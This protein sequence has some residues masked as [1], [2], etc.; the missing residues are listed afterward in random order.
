MVKDDDEEVL[1]PEEVKGEEYADQKLKKVPSITSVESLD[2]DLPLNSYT[3]DLEKRE[4]GSSEEDW[5][6]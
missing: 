3:E 4:G 2:R 6:K 1:K 5:E